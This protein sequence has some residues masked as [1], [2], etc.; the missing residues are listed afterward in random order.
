MDN[1]E[2][3]KEVTQKIGDLSSRKIRLEER[4]KSE[5]AQL[6]KLLKEVTDKGYD[7][8]KLTETRKEKEAELEKQFNSIEAE[9]KDLTQKISAMEI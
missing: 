4:L 1:A 7:P 6:E 2:R 9:L 5:K 3:F 8:K